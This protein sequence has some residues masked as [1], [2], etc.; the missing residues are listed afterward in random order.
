MLRR[1]VTVMRI[2]IFNILFFL[3]F[4]TIEVLKDDVSVLNWP[5]R[6]SLYIYSLPPW[7]DSRI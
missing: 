4:F 5:V 1:R 3:F 6:T 2:A 7:D